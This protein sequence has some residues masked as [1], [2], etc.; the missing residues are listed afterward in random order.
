MAALPSSRCDGIVVSRPLLLAGLVAVCSPLLHGAPKWRPITPADHATVAPDTA[1]LAN[2]A[3]LPREFAV[4]ASSVAG[5]GGG[6][7]LPLAF[8]QEGEAETFADA[9]RQ[10][11]IYFPY[12]SRQE[13]K[14]S[15]NW[16]DGYELETPGV[17]EESGCSDKFHYSPCLSLDQ[18]GRRGVFE[19]T[20]ALRLFHLPTESYPILRGLFHQATEDDNRLFSLAL[21]ASAAGAQRDVPRPAPAP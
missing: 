6:L 14:V 13:D 16:P 17:L 10:S 1:P 9:N 2:G 5:I 8:F 4:D 18:G 11:F 7:L 15:I 3:I 12:F 20:L 21:T 19:H